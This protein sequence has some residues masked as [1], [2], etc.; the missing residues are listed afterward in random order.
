MNNF[1]FRI[2]PDLG[3][4]LKNG[5]PPSYS[6]KIIR[7]YSVKTVLISKVY[8]PY[9]VLWLEYKIFRIEGEIPQLMVPL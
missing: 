9:L 3:L 7:S 4:N 1:H 5:F 2:V 6:T 8:A